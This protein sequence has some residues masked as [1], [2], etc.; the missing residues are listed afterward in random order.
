MSRSPEWRAPSTLDDERRFATDKVSGEGPD[1]ML[2][3]KLLVGQASAAQ[4]GLQP[5]FGRLLVAPKTASVSQ[6][7]WFND[8][9]RHRPNTLIRPL[10]TFSRRREKGKLMRCRDLGK[11]CKD[12]ST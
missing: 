1:R 2:T 11:S 5:D 4:P 10:A 6:T 8:T 9:R 7:H 3:H 12:Q